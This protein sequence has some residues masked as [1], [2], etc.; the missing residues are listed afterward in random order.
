MLRLAC[1]RLSA[2]IVG[3]M[4]WLFYQ[5]ALIAGRVA[6]EIS[7][8]RR[9]N[10]VRN[11]L[12]FVEG[13]QRRAR[14]AG[15]RAFQNVA[16]YWVDLTTLPHRRL[17]T[18]ERDHIHL[19]GG[20]HLHVLDRAGPVVV[21]SA[22][23]G[24]A[25]LVIQALTYRGRPFAALVETLDPP[26]FAD[27]LLRL[28]SVAG[29]RFYEANFAGVRACLEALR[30]GGLVGV[31]GDRDIQ[32]SGVPAVIAGRSVRLPRGPWELARRSGAVVLP[33][34]TAR[35]GADDFDVY[36]EEAFCVHPGGDPEAEVRRA[37]D[38]WAAVLERH[39]RRDPG[40]WTVLED[41]WEA[42]RCGQG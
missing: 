1:L 25:E 3:R 9:R 38:R 19:I 41:F 39:L 8:T 40:Q 29:G 23:T 26:Q 31:M 32:G 5:V 13:D 7:P 11:M 15:L 27:S 20:E 10:L 28:R 36:V 4:P 12:P 22:H 24:N 37:V 34:L 16:R 6:W 35:R 2:P 33:V 21:V 42:H 18:F 14:A 17:A 30:G